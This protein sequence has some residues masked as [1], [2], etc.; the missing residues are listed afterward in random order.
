[1]SATALPIIGQFSALERCSDAVATFAEQHPHLS[2]LELHELSRLLLG[3]LVR[4]ARPD[5][6]AA[7]ILCALIAVRDAPTAVRGDSRTISE[8]KQEPTAC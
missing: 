3:A 1:M 8:T 4:E 2:N 5:V 6:A 7:M